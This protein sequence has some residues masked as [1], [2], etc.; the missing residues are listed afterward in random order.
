MSS[1]RI[2]ASEEAETLL[3]LRNKHKELDKQIKERYSNYAPDY[4]INKLKTK[5]LWYKDEIHRITTRLKG[6]L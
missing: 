5:K 6:Y 1:L 4:E 2:E 3:L